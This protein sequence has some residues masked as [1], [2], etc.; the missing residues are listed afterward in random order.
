MV[1]VE[2]KDASNTDTRLLDILFIPES[3][4]AWCPEWQTPF[5]S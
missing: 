4:Y 3:D 1:T 2:G 5:N